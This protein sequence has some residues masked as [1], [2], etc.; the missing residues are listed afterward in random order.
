MKRALIL[1]V[2]LSLAGC[3][4]AFAADPAPTP[5]PPKDLTI[6]LGRLPGISVVAPGTYRIHLINTIPRAMYQT[7]TRIETNKV[8]QPFNKADVARAVEGD[9]CDK[10]QD[11]VRGE[12]RDVPSEQEVAAL[13]L[14]YEPRLRRQKCSDERIK[15]F[16]EEF[17]GKTET[18]ETALLP[19]LEVGDSVFVTVVRDAASGVAAKSLGTWQFDIGKREAQWLTFY[20]FNFAQSGDENYFTQTNA[21]TNPPT[22][23]I[24]KSTD[25][26]DNN[27][28]P[29][30]YF[31]RLP[32]QQT[33]FK[34]RWWGWRGEDTF[35]GVTAGLGFDFDNP[36]VFLGY[37]VGWGYNVMLTAGVVMHKEQRLKGQYDPNDVVAENLTEDQLLDSTYKPRAYVGLA[38]RFGSNPFGS[39]GGEA[40]GEAAKGEE[41]P[42]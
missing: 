14:A 2:L 11:K 5:D 28:S 22:Y 18:R 34:D 36:T 7:S 29:S 40:G 1:S 35:G 9:D 41:K 25:R 27:F 42:K 16:A 3:A 15:L 31:F 39:G 8:A 17:E 33:R 26:G 12:L 30:I 20:G 21:G 24:T 10:E 13:R 23:T 6:D 38:F 37:G 32:A 19:T 4:P